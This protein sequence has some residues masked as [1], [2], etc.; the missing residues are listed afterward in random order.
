M[1]PKGGNPLDPA[2]NE[3]RTTVD[4]S[5][6]AINALITRR[7]KSALQRNKRICQVACLCSFLC[8][9]LTGA[10]SLLLIASSG[11]AGLQVLASPYAA[12]VIVGSDGTLAALFCASSLICLGSLVAWFILRHRERTQDR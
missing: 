4:E 1:K 11:T 9:V 12:S 3:G 2:I 7:K 5:M 10:G 6:D 8:A